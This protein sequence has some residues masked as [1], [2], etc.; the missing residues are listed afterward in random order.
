MRPKLEVLQ[1]RVCVRGK[2]YVLTM[3]QP[4]QPSGFIHPLDYV[5]HCLEHCPWWRLLWWWLTDSEWRKLARAAKA[6]RRA[7]IR[8]SKDD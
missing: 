7:R 8:R 2:D 4:T 1:D 5:E 6:E 3:M